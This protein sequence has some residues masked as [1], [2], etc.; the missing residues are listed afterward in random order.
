[1]TG[2]TLPRDLQK[3]VLEGVDLSNRD[4][5]AHVLLAADLTRCVLVN[6]QLPVDL[7][8]C[9]LIGCDLSGRDL[10]SYDLSEALLADSN[11]S[12]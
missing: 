9:V 6:C 8:C 11:L 12:K 2:C 5:R 10:R 3:T 1:M 4:L 7:R